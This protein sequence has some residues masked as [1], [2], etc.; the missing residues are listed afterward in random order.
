MSASSLHKQ[1]KKNLADVENRIAN[2]AARGGRLGGDVELIAVTKYAPWPAIEALVEI[3]HRQLG[4]NRPQ[5]LLERAALFAEKSPQSELQWHLIGQLQRNKVRAV[6]PAVALIHSVDSVRLLEKIDEVAGE[7]GLNP[8]VLLQV[9]ISHEE[10]KSGFS[11]EDVRE[12]L[13]SRTPLAHVQCVGLMTMAPLTEDENVIRSVFCGLRELRDE[14][15]TPDRPLKHLSMGM[16]GDFEIAIEEGATL[17]RVGS[18]LFEGCEGQEI[19][20]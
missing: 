4:E 16:S 15:A 17:V 13:Q 9:N 6:L 18:A 12:V 20:A 19:Q 2:A 11:A 10:S 1:L 14:L 7:L 3:G 5:Q 8:Q